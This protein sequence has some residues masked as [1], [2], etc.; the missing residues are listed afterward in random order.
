MLEVFLG[1][2]GRR[3]AVCVEILQE[4]DRCGDVVARAVGHCLGD[5]SLTGGVAEVA[6]HVPVGEPP[7]QV[8]LISLVRGEQVEFL[9]EPGRDPFDA[10]L[11]GGQHAE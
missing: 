2:G 7:D 10:W 11:V 1:G 9:V 8:G 5:V 3:G 4:S 6:Q